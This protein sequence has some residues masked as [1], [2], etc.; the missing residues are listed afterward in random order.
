MITTAAGNHLQFSEMSTGDPGAISAGEEIVLSPAGG[1]LPS[2]RE[3]IFASLTLGNGT[4]LNASVT[5]SGNGGIPYSRGDLDF[6]GV[7]DVAD[8]S[9]FVTNNYSSLTGLSG[10]QSYA[11]GD[12]DG[13]GDNDYTDF[14]LFKSDFNL[15]NGAA[16]LRRRYWVCRN[17]ARCDLPSHWPWSG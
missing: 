16:R 9:V 4:L 15:A 14:R 10:A 7:I 6:D 11:L 5:F 13:D 3:D 1:W 2:P 17:R 8:W 12:L